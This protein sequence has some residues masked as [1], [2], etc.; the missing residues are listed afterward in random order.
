MAQETTSKQAQNPDQHHYQ[1]L[2]KK[3]TRNINPRSGSTAIHH[4]H[5]NPINHESPFITTTQANNDE[6]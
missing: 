2:Q 4:H 6:T 1:Q 5:P 3:K